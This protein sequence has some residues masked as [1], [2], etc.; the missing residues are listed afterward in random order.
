MS[1]RIEFPCGQ[2][3]RLRA[4]TSGST[5]R[6]RVSCAMRSIRPGRRRNHGGAGVPNLRVSEASRIKKWLLI[7]PWLAAVLSGLLAA[8]CFVPF[9]QTW[10]CWIALTPLLAAVW[11]FGEGIRRRW[12]HDFFLGYADRKSVV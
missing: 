4:P 10:L 9:G 12:L 2:W 7:W 3:I 11:F 1:S 5:P 6:M 8:F